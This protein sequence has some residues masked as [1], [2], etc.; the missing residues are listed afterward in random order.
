MGFVDSAILGGTAKVR[1]A[2]A[3]GILTVL[4]AVVAG[5]AMYVGSYSSER[6]AMYDPAA[7]TPT[8]LQEALKA[9]GCTGKTLGE[10]LTSAKKTGLV[11]WQRRAAHDGN[12][13][14]G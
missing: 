9:L 5:A 14:H 13:W 4:I 1:I 10:L 8:A 6:L 3:A 2:G 11:K 12:R 7:R